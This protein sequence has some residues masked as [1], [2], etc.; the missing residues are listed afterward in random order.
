M[1]GE[2]ALPPG[3]VLLERGV[4]QLPTLGARGVDH[5]RLGWLKDLL[6]GGHPLRGELLGFLPR[7]IVH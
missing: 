6:D 4:E 7:A 5:E 2:A 3:L 1:P